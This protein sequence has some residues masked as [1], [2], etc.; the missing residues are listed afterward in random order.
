MAWP[1]DPTVYAGLLGLFLGHAWLA[2]DRDLPRINSL[3]FGVGLLSLWA[4]LETPLDVLSDSYLDSAHMFQHVLLGVVAPPLL[5]LGLNRD[6]AAVLVRVPGVR[7][8]TEPIAAQVISAAVMIGWHLPPLY[9]ATLY[10]EQL[11]VLEHFCFVAGGVVFWWPVIEATAEHCRWRLSPLALLLYL[12]IG[13]FPQDAVALPLQFSRTP[14]YEF[15]AHVPRIVPGLDPVT[16]QTAA[17]A[18]LMLFGKSSYL[19]GAVVVFLRWFNADARADR[20]SAARPRS[21]S[22]AE[23]FGKWH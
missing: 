6:M 1:F 19:V 16:D 12:F 23:A 7:R 13:T 4:A 18:I 22:A 9:D 20:E 21:E 3:Y 17:G 14:F 11:H 2:R 15:Y 8:I 5:L 10:S